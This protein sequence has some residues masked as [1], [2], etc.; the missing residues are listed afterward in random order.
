MT[1]DGS[2]K[3][4]ADHKKV[5][6]RFVPPMIHQFNLQETSWSRNAA[7]H[8]FWVGLHKTHGLGK[9]LEIVHALAQD[10]VQFSNEKIK[11]FAIVL[12]E[13][14]ALNESMKAQLRGAASLRRHR[15]LIV[16]SV[17]C[18]LRIYPNFPLRFL[19]GDGDKLP[20]IDQ[21]FS[22]MRELFAELMDK[23]TRTTVL[24]QACTLSAAMSCGHHDGCSGL[25]LANLAPIEP[26]S[27]HVGVPELAAGVRSAVAMMAKD[28][29]YSLRDGVRPFGNGIGMKILVPCLRRRQRRM[30]HRNDHMT[31]IVRITDSFEE[32]VR[33]EFNELLWEMEASSMNFSAT[34]KRL[35]RYT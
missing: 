31:E 24:V 15:Q 17:G 12:G 34:R 35:R 28:S 20:P 21:S 19:M 11:P 26:L 8:L 18:A 2:Y 30:N 4:L 23:S 1:N 16:G 6:T 27:R 3:V 33:S 7:P 9:T 29:S 25:K 32:H 10:A 13:L 14:D 22:T 5:G